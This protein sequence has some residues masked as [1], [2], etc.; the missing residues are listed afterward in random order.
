MTMTVVLLLSLQL[1][2]SLYLISSLTIVRVPTA[3]SFY[4]PRIDF[5]SSNVSP[6]RAKSIGF[7]KMTMELIPISKSQ[8]KILMPQQVIVLHNNFLSN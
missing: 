4:L 7:K 8:F 6:M 1:L 3:N 2:G 5:Y